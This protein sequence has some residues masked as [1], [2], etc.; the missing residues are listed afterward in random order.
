MLKIHE[1]VP[2]VLLPQQK[3]V[4]TYLI[5]HT[6]NFFKALNFFK[7]FISWTNDLVSKVLDYHSRGSI[8]NHMIAARSTQPFTV[9]TLN[10]WN[11][12]ELNAKKQ[13]FSL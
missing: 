7:V 10:S 5:R 6:F 1:H 8:Q 2:F 11:Y 9:L 12:W 4:K 13:T 3:A